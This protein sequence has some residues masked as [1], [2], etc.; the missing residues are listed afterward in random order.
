VVFWLLFKK[1]KKVQK[2]S[3]KDA[4]LDNL[5][6]LREQLESL[7]VQIQRLEKKRD[8][9]KKEYLKAMKKGDNEKARMVE[10]EIKNI[11]TKIKSLK[12]T[13]SILEVEIKRLE[14][15]DDYMVAVNSMS[16]IAEALKNN[17][18]IMDKALK[19]HTLRVINNLENAM[20]RMKSADLPTPS[21]TAVVKTLLDESGEISLPKVESYSMS[22]LTVNAPTP[23]PIAMADGGLVAYKKEDLVNK[24]YQ[25]IQIYIA[26]GR[27]HKLSVKKIAQHLGV[28]EIEVRKA[29]E[30]L[31]RQG[32]I[33]IRRDK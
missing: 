15:T 33:K 7:E 11:N 10:A 14:H 27:A 13:K 16:K 3:L 12:H 31:E 20:V 8:D 32:K 28:S 19:P 4:Y 22:P 24:V 18:D 29:L 21:T 30:E 23:Q 1:R 9:L 5:F 26:Y 17:I 6:E 2:R 25:V